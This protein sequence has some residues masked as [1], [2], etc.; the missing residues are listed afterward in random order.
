DHAVGLIGGWSISESPVRIAMRLSMPLFAVLM[1]YFLRSPRILTGK[2]STTLDIESLLQNRWVQIGFAAA[3]VNLVFFPAYQCL[4][5]LCSLLLAAI[6]ARL[7][8][9]AFP[10]FVLVVAVFPIDPT[11]GWPQ[12]GWMD[13]PLSIV[14]GFVA[15]GN[16]QAR[17]GHKAALIVAA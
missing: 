15:L 17:Y 14:V 7:S 8:G 4:D 1:G 16:L 9:G 3:L 11:D 6:I 12:L 5:I 10:W 13:F 2:E